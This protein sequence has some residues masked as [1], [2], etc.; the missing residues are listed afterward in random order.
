M[1][2]QF[3]WYRWVNFFWHIIQI[4]LTNIH[5]LLNLWSYFVWKKSINRKSVKMKTFYFW[6]TVWLWFPAVGMIL[7]PPKCSCSISASPYPFPQGGA[8]CRGLRLPWCPPAVLLTGML[9]KHPGC[10]G[11]ALP[12]AGEQRYQENQR[13]KMLLLTKLSQ[14]KKGYLRW[15]QGRLPRRNTETLYKHSEVGL[16][17]PKP[18]WGWIW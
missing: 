3:S 17:K 7:T 8:W 12:R 6:S 9:A 14:R 1:L 16:G 11:C 10:Q 4:W 2:P 5:V 13:R 18:I 15:E